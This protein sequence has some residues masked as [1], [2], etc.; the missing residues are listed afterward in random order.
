M[1]EVMK[2]VLVARDMSQEEM[3]A[4]VDALTPHE[5]QHFKQTICM[6]AMCYGKESTMQAVVVVGRAS[7]DIASLTSVNCDDME[8]SILLNA[9]NEFYGYVNLAGAPPKEQFN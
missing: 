1:D 3:S 8:A 2:E 4:L 6:L 7:E 9:A 5:R